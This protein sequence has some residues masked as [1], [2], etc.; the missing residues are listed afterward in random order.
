MTGSAAIE[1]AFTAAGIFNSSYFRSLAIWDVAA[2]VALVR[3]AGGEAWLRDARGWR[4]FERFEAP[5]KV[6]AKREPSL[7][8][9]RMPLLLGEPEVL[10]VRRGLIRQPSALSRLVRKV[11]GGR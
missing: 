4:P 5:S 7:R 6:R 9:W 2:G 3:A 1:A 11:G 8:D 10:A